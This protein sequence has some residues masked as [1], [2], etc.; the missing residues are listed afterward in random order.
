ML[1]GVTLLTVPPKAD[2]IT[3]T[4]NNTESF[5]RT[6]SDDT[7]LKTSRQDVVDVAWDKPP[8]QEHIDGVCELS[9]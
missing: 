8:E 4:I 5:G 1:A 9:N 6:S 2:N 3:T 7:A